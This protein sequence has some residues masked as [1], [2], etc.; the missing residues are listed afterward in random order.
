MSPT[1]LAAVAKVL[2]LLEKHPPAAEQWDR[3][4]K[5]APSL[6]NGLRKWLKEQL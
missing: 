4:E 6:R 2:E 1:D 3:D 5:M